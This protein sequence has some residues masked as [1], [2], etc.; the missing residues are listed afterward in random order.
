MLIPIPRWML[1][2]SATQRYGAPTKDNWGNETR[3]NNRIL[4]YVRFD[5]ASK[6]VTTKD[7]REVRLS[8]IMFFDCRNSTP[9]EATFAVGDLI[10]QTNGAKYTVAGGV[11]PVWEGEK[12]HHFEVELC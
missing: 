4:G 2:H 11:D 9:S 12:A 3:P 6:L 8:A 10:E 7:N 1:P 5:P